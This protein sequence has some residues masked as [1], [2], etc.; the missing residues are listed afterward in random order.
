MPASP[1]AVR[2]PAL[3]E[4]QRQ[5]VRELLYRDSP[6]VAAQIVAN[7]LGAERRLAIYRTNARETFALA[8]EAAYP[9][10][11]ACVGPQEFRR[12][13]WAY[14][15]ACPSPAGNLFHAGT[16]L[17]GFLAEHVR[18]TPDDYLID[19]ARLEW[20]V[21]ESLWAGDCDTALDLAALAAVPAEH[22]A[23]LR[24]LLHPSVRLLRSEYGVLRLW[25][26]RQIGQPV[27]QAMPAP[28][29][30]L[31]RRLDAG[32]QLQKL[33]ELDLLWLERVQGGASLAD[34]AAALPATAQDELGALL[35]RWVSSGVVTGFTLQGHGP[36]EELK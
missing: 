30:L 36:G 35:V 31:V 29:N 4:L 26:A 12:L 20:A 34:S 23:E 9:L 22:Q 10:L 3:K 7:G 2:D 25:E 21:Q 28:E 19:V 5:F 24:F 18:G 33:G 11:L 14:Q 16:R 13:A 17:P 6:E 27:S 8:L 1:E 15:Q 32:I